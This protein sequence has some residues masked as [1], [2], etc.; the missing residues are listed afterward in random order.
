MFRMSRH[1]ALRAQQRGFTPDLIEAILDYGDIE[2]PAGDNCVEIGV[3][4]R[5][6]HAL[7]KSGQCCTAIGVGFAPSLGTVSALMGGDHER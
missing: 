3:S 5:A 7:C 2:R 6:A 1:A 4:R